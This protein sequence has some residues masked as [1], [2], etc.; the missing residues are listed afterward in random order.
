MDSLSDMSPPHQNLV[1]GGL[2]GITM[3]DESSED[4]LSRRA[5]KRRG[6]RA[7]STRRT[8]PR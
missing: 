3:V 7:T 2:A 6:E 8:V 5:S 1:F 4:E